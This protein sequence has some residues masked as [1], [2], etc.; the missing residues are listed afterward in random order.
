MGG[1]FQIV[2]GILVAVVLGL[3][4]S[5]QG[6]DTALL[7][8]IAVCCMVL[9]AAVTYLQPVMDFI[10]KLQNIGS[11]DNQWI[12]V[13]L[14]ATGIGLVA[15]LASLICADSGNTALGKTVQILAASAV[16]W[17]SIPLMS[18]LMELIQKILGEI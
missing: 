6:K 12:T 8:S 16:L 13:M 11:L 17:L 15:E 2:A 18:A 9:V 4:L 3:V 7:L 10:K 14:K 1:Y 5:K